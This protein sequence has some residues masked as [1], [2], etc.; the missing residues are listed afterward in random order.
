MKPA[1]TNSSREEDEGKR[2]WG[3][4]KAHCKH[5]QKY[6][7]ESLLFKFFQLLLYWGIL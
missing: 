1:V 4:P 7:N 6:H 2:W 5:I 3:Q